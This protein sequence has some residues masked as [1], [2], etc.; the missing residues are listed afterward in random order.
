MSHYAK[1]IRPG[2][3]RVD[4]TDPTLNEVFVSAYDGEKPVIVALNM[5]NISQRI[6]F[7]LRNHDISELERYR[8]TQDENLAQDTVQVSGD[9]FTRRLPPG[10]ITTYK[11]P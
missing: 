11:V 7:K 2:Y 5:D 8:T 4:V 3:H 6:R 10:S 9:S 1:F